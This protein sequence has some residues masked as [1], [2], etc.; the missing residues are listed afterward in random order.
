MKKMAISIIVMAIMFF[1]NFCFAEGNYK[2]GVLAKN[3]PVKA[4]KMWKSTGEYL[5]AKVDGNF[6]IVPLDFDAVFPAIEKGDVDFF[7]VNS[8]MF[9]TAKVKFGAKAIATMI[10]SRQGKPLK[11]FGGVIFTSEEN[12]DINSMGDLPGKTFMAVKKSSFGGWQMAYMELLNQKIDP[13][14]DF[15]KLDFGGKHDNVVLAVQNGVVEAGTVRTDT[16]ERMAASGL[17][18]LSEFKII[19][20]KKYEDFPFVCS[21]A[22]YPEWPI[23]KIKG[24]SDQIAEKVVAALKQLKTTDKAAKDAKIVGWTN[25]LDYQGVEELQSKL[26]IGAYK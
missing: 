9:I 7:L 12:D 11:S 8:S 24:T 19:N 10:N 6:E 4:L 20:S 25:A 14:K 23:A 18:E 5:S 13:F 2:I 16:L 21:T 26:K 1:S 22:L 15:S 3:G 17:V